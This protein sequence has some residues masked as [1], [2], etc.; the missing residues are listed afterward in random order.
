MTGADENSDG[1]LV[2]LT[3]QD[4][5]EPAQT[6]SADEAVREA[7]SLGYPVV[8]KLHSYRITHKTDVGGVRLNLGNAEAVR[9][10]FEG[11][12][13]KLEELGQAE[14]FDGVTV[15]LMVKAAGSGDEDTAAAGGG[16]PGLGPEADRRVNNGAMQKVC[17]KLGF[18]IF[19]GEGVGESRVKAVKVL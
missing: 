11:I 10:A 8:L 2:I 3:P 13:E 18:E 1:M 5:T 7:E 16:G 6:T 17:R 4:M 12:R 15:Q 9:S 19:Q 14:A